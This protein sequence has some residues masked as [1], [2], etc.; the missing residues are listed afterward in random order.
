VTRITSSDQVLMLLREQ[1]QRMGKGRV[2]G[3]D[4]AASSARSGSSPPMA[5]VLSLA[6]RG[7]VG[8]EEFRRTL[9]RALLTEQLSEQVAQDPGVQLIM[10]DVFRIVSEDEEGRRLLDRAAEQ[11]K[12]A[13]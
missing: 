4:R 2:G 10:D 1:L 11:L 5:R 6:A 7:E 9:V 8:E 3:A 13:V 12:T